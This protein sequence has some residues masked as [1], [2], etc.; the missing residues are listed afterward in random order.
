MMLSKKRNYHEGN[1]TFSIHV[2]DFGKKKNVIYHNIQ[3][4]GSPMGINYNVLPL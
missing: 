2:H 1:I 3:Y 4:N